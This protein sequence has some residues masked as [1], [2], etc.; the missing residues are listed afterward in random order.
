MQCAARSELDAFKGD[1]NDMAE[2]LTR[3]E[4]AA[5]V[6]AGGREALGGVGLAVGGLALTASLSFG[7]IVIVFSGMFIAGV[8][9]IFHGLH[10]RSQAKIA[11]ARMPDARVVKH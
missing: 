10:R 2:H 8:G 6:V 3:P 4:I 5:V 11:L 7:Q 1:R 9:M